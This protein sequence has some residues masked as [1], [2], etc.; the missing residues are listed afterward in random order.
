MP[1]SKAVAV[2]I[3]LENIHYSSLNNYAETPNWSKIVDTCKKY[4]RIVSI[5]AFGDWIAFSKEVPEIQRNGIQPVFVPLS[6]DGKSSLDCYLTVSAMKLFYQNTALDTIILASGDRDYIPM[7][8]ELK[9]LGK[10]IIILAVP[11]TLSQDLTRIAD[12]VI[13]YESNQDNTNK[14]DGSHDL[15]ADTQFIIDT[16]KSL[17]KQSFQERWVNLAMIGLELKRRNPSFS[18]QN[19]GYAKLVEMLDAISDVELSYDNHEKTIALARIHSNAEGVS[20]SPIQHGEVIN[21]HDSFGFIR[22]DDGE[23]NLFF[24]ISKVSD[25]CT[26]K[27]QRGDR[28]RYT[29]YRTHRGNNAENVE[30]IQVEQEQ[31]EE[32]EE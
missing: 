7:L 18:H 4:G 28:V 16:L 27:L 19:H 10:R 21:L 12:D 25:T 31:K 20:E 15:V 26:D 14:N 22:P 9:A 29:S 13:S 30:R 11:D 17:E 5:Q 32:A 24:H 2:F 8:A 6:Q 3:D 1:E 23:D